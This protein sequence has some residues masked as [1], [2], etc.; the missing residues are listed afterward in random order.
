VDRNVITEQQIRAGYYSSAYEA[1]EALRANWLH[2][3]RPEPTPVWV[4]VNANR[5]GGVEALRTIL[6]RSVVCIRFYD[7][8]T[9]T[10]RW[11]AGHGQGVIF[12]STLPSCASTIV[13]FK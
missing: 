4:Y 7:G 5:A 2:A 1:V 6:P 9:A 13:P 10:A 8:L 12:V 11:G 3:R